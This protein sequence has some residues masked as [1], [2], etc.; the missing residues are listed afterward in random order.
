MRLLELLFL[1]GK[2]ESFNDYTLCTFAEKTENEYTNLADYV[3]TFTSVESYIDLHY[4]N[5]R[6]FNYY[7][8]D[9]F[10][11]LIYAVQENNS[12]LEFLYDIITGKVGKSSE[13]QPIEGIIDYNYFTQLFRKN[14]FTNYLYY[15]F[16]RVP[17]G[18]IASLKIK[19]EEEVEEGIII[20]KV[21]CAFVSISS[22]DEEMK[23]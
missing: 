8:G 13:V 17:I 21:G 10:D 20:S 1:V 7:E 4:I 23:N 15:D 12:K 18:H 6:T 14:D 9:E 5:F 22:N 11:L 2:K 3:K 16:M 19:P